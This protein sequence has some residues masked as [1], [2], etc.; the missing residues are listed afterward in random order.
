MLPYSGPV[1]TW[2]P[3]MPLAR[4]GYSPFMIQAI[5]SSLWT[6]SSTLKSPHNQVKDI[7][8]AG[9]QFLVCIETDKATF[10]R[11]VNLRGQLRV[12]LNSGEAFLQSIGEGVRH[13]DEFDVLVRMERLAGRSGAASAAANQADPQ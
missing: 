9:E 11:D 6:C 10:F 13:S 4:T 12:C 3:P 1:R 7:H 5:M 2:R 8:P